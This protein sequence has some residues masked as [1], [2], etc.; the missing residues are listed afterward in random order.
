MML[1][2]VNDGQSR[3]FRFEIAYHALNLYELNVLN[4]HHQRPYIIP[5]LRERDNETQLIYTLGSHLTLEQWLR[6]SASD[7]HDLLAVIEALAVLLAEAS[8]HCLRLE[9]FCLEPSRICYHTERERVELI[10]LPVREASMSFEQQWTKML[11]T[12]ETI[13]AI[14]LKS[15][16]KEAFMM[17]IA[18]GEARYERREA[19]LKWVKQWFETEHVKRMPSDDNKA[20]S[21]ADTLEAVVIPPVRLASENH[22]FGN[23]LMQ[24]WG[25]L[26]RKASAVDA[27]ELK[28]P[29]DPI[30]N[31]PESR[32]L[33]SAAF[34]QDFTGTS[35]LSSQEQLKGKLILQ[36]QQ[37]CRVFEIS[38]PVTRIGRNKVVC[39]VVI[40]NDVTV[41]RL[42]AEVHRIDQG[43]FLKDLDSLNGTYLN[44]QRLE[45]QTLY[46]LKGSDVLRLSELEIQFF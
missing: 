40:D 26:K 12:L 23:V 7:Y 31:K 45:T 42:H 19:F 2:F 9:K 29:N 4:R 39:D 22:K 21:R 38:K 30:V 44:G 1:E 20:I 25:K 5:L 36:N 24:F 14:C 41:G 16:G 17:L 34:R 32:K 18:D 11:R 27:A 46:K 37:P 13:S 6:R 3:L 33:E 43:Y 8:N 28:M 15:E 10:Y 35:L